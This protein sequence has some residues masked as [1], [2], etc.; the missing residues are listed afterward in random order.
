MAIEH[1]G[2]SGSYTKSVEDSNTQASNKFSNP[3]N[4]PTDNRSKP[5]HT[6]NKPTGR[7]SQAHVEP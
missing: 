3:I 5:S 6:A 2:V 1:K 7:D 4:K